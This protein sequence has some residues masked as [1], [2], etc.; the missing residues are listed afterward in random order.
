MI[1]LRDKKVQI[2]YKEAFNVSYA[3]LMILKRRLGDE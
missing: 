3:L 2:N 1:F